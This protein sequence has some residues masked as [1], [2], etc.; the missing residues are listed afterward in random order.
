MQ[1]IVLPIE[2]KTAQN[3]YSR[4]VVFTTEHMQVVVMNLKPLEDI[5]KETHASV[6]QFLRIESGEVTVFLDG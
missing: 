6:D 1:G 2:S 5:G 4:E 3:E